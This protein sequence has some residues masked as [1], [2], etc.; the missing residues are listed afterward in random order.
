M[1]SDSD[2]KNTKKKIVSTSV[3]KYVKKAITIVD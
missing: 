2:N 3:K 1:M